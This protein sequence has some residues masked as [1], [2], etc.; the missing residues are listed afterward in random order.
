MVEM[1]P[2]TQTGSMGIIPII[3]QRDTANITAMQT[4]TIPTA[5]ITARADIAAA[6]TTIITTATLIATTATTIGTTEV[7]SS[8]TH[9]QFFGIGACRGAA[10]SPHYLLAV[11]THTENPAAL[12][13]R[14][15]TTVKTLTEDK[16]EEGEEEAEE[17]NIMGSPQ[18]HPLSKIYHQ[19]NIK[20]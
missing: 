5:G 19:N 6:T 18:H 12:V 3:S 2:A 20:I 9:L 8:I 7:A 15:T 14:L 16:A 17:G 10:Q 13:A 4:A 11:A 1:L